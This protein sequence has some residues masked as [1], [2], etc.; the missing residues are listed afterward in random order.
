MV[1][2]TMSTA[3]TGLSNQQVRHTQYVGGR[4]GCSQPSS[5]AMAS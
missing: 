5:A 3:V 4:G 2:R 1:S